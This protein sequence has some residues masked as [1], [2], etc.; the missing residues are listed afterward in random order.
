M[1]QILSDI[2]DIVKIITLSLT[3]GIAFIAIVLGIG[4][5]FQTTQRIGKAHTLATITNIY[6]HAGK[7]KQNPRSLTFNSTFVVEEVSYNNS[8]YGFLSFIHPEVGDKLSIYYNPDNP[9]DNTMGDL[10]FI[11]QPAVI[12]IFISGLSSRAWLLHKKLKD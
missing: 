8:S 5:L 11:W 2:L 12:C 7:S 6:V 3:L 9:S 10:W 1:L 4:A